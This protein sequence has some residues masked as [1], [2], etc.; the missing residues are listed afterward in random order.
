MISGKL[1]I[2]EK[3][4][5]YLDALSGLAKTHFTVIGL[6]LLIRVHLTKLNKPVKLGINTALHFFSK[7]TP[8]ISGEERAKLREEYK[9]YK[10]QFKAEHTLGSFCADSGMVCVVYLD[11][12]LKVNPHFKEWADKHDWCVTIIENF[13]GDIEYEVDEEGEAHIVGKGNLN[14]YT[15]QSGL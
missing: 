9:Q 14:F 15:S 11:E 10:K 8:D 6:V 13:D 5:L 4:Y 12:I 1:L 3:I 7:L 2:T